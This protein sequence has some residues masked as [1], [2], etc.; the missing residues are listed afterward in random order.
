MPQSE[1]RRWIERIPE[2]I[3]KIIALEGGNA[4]QEGKTGETRLSA[5]RQREKERAAYWR[6]KR[7]AREAGTEVQF[8]EEE[9][10]VWREARW[11]Q[12]SQN[13]AEDVDFEYVGDISTSEVS[14]LL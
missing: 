11:P 7:Q 2:N 12:D 8:S 13:R 4:Y 9:R 5:A 14:Q 1:I 6:A 3:A 10:R